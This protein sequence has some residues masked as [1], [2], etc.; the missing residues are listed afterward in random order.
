MTSAL[1]IVQAVRSDGFA[2]VE[3]YIC[4]VSGELHGRGHRV[5][6][7][8]GDPAVMRDRLPGDVRHVPARTTREVAVALAR[9]RN[10][11]VVHVHMSSAEL[12]AV[13]T[14]PV[15]RAP[16]VAT[17]HFAATRGRSAVLRS[18]LRAVAAGLSAELSISQFVADRS[19][20]G[21]RVLANGVRDRD[22]VVRRPDRTVLVMQRL[23]REKDTDVAVEAFAASGLVDDGWVM[24]IAGRG[25]LEPDVRRL[26]H[27]RGLSAV[28]ELLGFV[29]DADA[30]RAGATVLL[31][32]AAEEPFG[33]SVLEAVA[34]G[35]PVV[36]AAGGAHLETLAGSPFLF[37]PG[38]VTAAAAAL[39]AVASGGPQMSEVTRRLRAEQQRSFSLG[40]H[41]DALERLYVELSGGTS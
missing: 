14:R 5:V 19:G 41:V 17:R 34:S 12:A 28:V 21:S 24:R 23:E 9:L 38:N 31:A 27:D 35:L 15:H 2:G 10:Q 32:P 11:S 8:G 29:D 1:Q 26:V 22:E 6:C 7:V 30:V 39:R 16:V 36:A 3:Q 25:A 40:G 18:A 37:A 4:D 33:L 20:P 13:V